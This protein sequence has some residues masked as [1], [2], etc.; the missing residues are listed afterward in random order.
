VAKVTSVAEVNKILAHG[1][2]EE[3]YFSM[4]VTFVGS[5]MS[6]FLMRVAHDLIPDIETI[7]M[8]SREN[9]DAISISFPVPIKNSI[10]D[11]PLAFILSI[12]LSLNCIAVQWVPCCSFSYGIM[13][14]SFH[15]VLE[16]IPAKVHS[17][18]LGVL[19]GVIHIDRVHGLYN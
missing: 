8:S 2:P 6:Q 11:L 15:V 5:K 17:L 14:H 1:V 19:E 9:V 7:A 3:I 13:P 10:Q 4:L 12:A 18:M 16:L